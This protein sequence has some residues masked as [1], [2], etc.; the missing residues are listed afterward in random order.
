MS[1]KCIWKHNTKGLKTWFHKFYLQLTF[2]WIDLIKYVIWLNVLN[3]NGKV[4]IKAIDNGLR[5]REKCLFCLYK[6][7]R[8]QPALPLSLYYCD[9]SAQGNDEGWTSLPGFQGSLSWSASS[10]LTPFC[11]LNF[12][13][14]SMPGMLTHKDTKHKHSSVALKLDA[15]FPTFL[16]WLT[17]AKTGDL[18]RLKNDKNLHLWC[19][20]LTIFR[21]LWEEPCVVMWDMA[22]ACQNWRWK[23]RV[24]A[25][26]PQNLFRRVSC[27]DPALAEC[28]ASCLDVL[29]QMPRGCGW[30]ENWDHLGP[31]FTV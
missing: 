7:H 24:V 18:P 8:K 15:G 1:C 12:D 22:V 13:L 29:F 5:T 30:V 25:K 6:S 28:L 31:M 21:I 4:Q 27:D 20:K 3:C 17:L 26:V 9:L 11:A 23:Q 16:T 14:S 19:L 10:A 2:K